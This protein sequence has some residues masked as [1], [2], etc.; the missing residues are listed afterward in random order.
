MQRI[1]AGRTVY[2]TSYVGTW[3]NLYP[4]IQFRKDFRLSKTSFSVK[5]ILT[6]VIL[7]YSF[8]YDNL[9]SISV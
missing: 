3:F 5:F 4:E 8:F 6:L 9:S 1:A 2:F 7:F